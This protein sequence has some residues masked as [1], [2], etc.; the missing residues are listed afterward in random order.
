MYICSTSIRN[1]LS[2]VLRTKLKQDAIIDNKLKYTIFENIIN[3]L[4]NLFYVSS[5]FEYLENVSCCRA[6]LLAFD[7]RA[8]GERKEY[9]ILLQKKKAERFILI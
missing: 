8:Q 2:W 7:K 5:K 9:L 3:I 1:N 4:R 6:R